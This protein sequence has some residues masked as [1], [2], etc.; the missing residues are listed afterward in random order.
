MGLMDRDAYWLDT[1]M[2]AQCSPN[3]RSLACAMLVTP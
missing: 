3:G 2:S 1:G